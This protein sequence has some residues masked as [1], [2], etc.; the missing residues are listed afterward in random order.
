MADFLIVMGAGPEPARLFEAGLRVAA[1]QGFGAPV[2]T[3]VRSGVRVATF[4]RRASPRAPEI[5]EEGPRWALVSGTCLVPDAARSVIDEGV[6]AVA[7][8]ADGAFAL[9]AGDERTAELATDPIGT[10]HVHVRVG[11]GASAFASSALW[12]AAL[13]DS[14]LDATACEEFLAT[15]VIYE[16]R[17]PWQAV[18]ALAAATRFALGASGARPVARTWQ[19]EDLEPGSIRGTEAVDA[20]G[21]VMLDVGARLGDAVERPVADLTAGWDSRL[22]CGFLMRAGLPIETTV[23]GPADGADV[24]LSGRIAR[25]LGLRHLVLPLG[26]PPTADEVLDAVELTDGL[27]NAIGYARILRVHRELSGRFGASLNGSFGEV[28]RGYW[29]EILRPSPDAVGPLDPAAISRARYA[30][31]APD[32]A[33]FGPEARPSPVEHFTDLVARTD[34]AVT[35]D[36]PMSFRLDHTY[37]RLRMRSWHGRIASSTDRL[38]PCLSPLASRAALEVLLRTPAHER[39]GNRFARQVLARF[40]PRLAALPLESGG[41]ALPRTVANAWRFAPEAL[42]FTRRAFKKLTGQR[43]YARTLEETSAPR[44]ALLA[45]ERIADR[46]RPEV[47][48]LGDHVDRDRLAGVLTAMRA[49]AWQHDLA[50]GNLLALEL[51]LDRARALR[52]G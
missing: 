5:V 35:G 38:W 44:L 39:V 51:A 50:F 22:L 31:G 26:A 14:P 8:R 43:T 7:A 28:A 45:D 9:A 12:L 23:T 6:E 16:D 46:L 30:A 32:L 10:H 18:R 49:P 47:M 11:D 42:G 33:L 15:G 40:A 17:T 36:V 13:G 29:W 20:F 34:R 4:A 1:G 48:A 2:Q 21:A 3:V 52:R 19:P 25:E 27:V 24:L 41:P 37:L